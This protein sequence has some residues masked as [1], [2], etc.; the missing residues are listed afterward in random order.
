M[1]R[2]W[3]LL[4]IL[5]LALACSD[6]APT[7]STALSDLPIDVPIPVP[8]PVPV[9]L[10]L[11]TLGGASSYAND[12]NS[13]GTVV[14]Q[15]DNAAGLSRAFRWTATGGMTDLG[16]LPG[17]DWS[18]ACCITDDGRILGVSG[19]TT[20]STSR[21]T[22]VVWSPSGEITALAIPL[23]P[24]AP[25][26]AVSDFNERGDFVGW[27]VVA[28]QHAW[29]WSEAQGK[30]DLTANIP[31]TGF[32]GIASD[33]DE[34]GLV[35]ATNRVVNSCVPPSGSCWRVF[36]WSYE[37]GFRNLGTP[38]DNPNTT[39][40]GMGLGAGPTVVGRASSGPYRWTEATGFT[41]LP[42]PAGGY[43][44]AV[45]SDAL[46]VGAAWDPTLLAY[47]ATAWSRSGGSIRLSPDDTN[48]QI[49]TE[50]NDMGLVV[51]W[52]AQNAGGNHATL[53]VLGPA[54]EVLARR[55]APTPAASVGTVSQAAA[56]AAVAANACISNTD[57]MV[58]RGAL[59][60]CENRGR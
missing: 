10:D 26:G 13:D 21:G 19:L 41:I 57:A 28:H 1:W 48:P 9:R 49:A 55:A 14:G 58:S 40:T 8:L 29:I 34:S 30:Y 16:T 31:A 54:S 46:A 56:A 23:L 59:L 39:V 25:F 37:T 27:D 11:G 18:T 22:P 4:P 5:P 42:T 47:Q 33:I 36:L 45:N 3:V 53:W 52:S 60:A 35:L 44:T 51:G 32:E 12:I 15:A 6:A 50:V 17:D 20:V 7:A 43:A 38:G 2:T 24:N